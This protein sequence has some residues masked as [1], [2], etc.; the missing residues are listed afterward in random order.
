[1]DCYAHTIFKFQCPTRFPGLPAPLVPVAF[2]RFVLRVGGSLHS[3]SGSH[4]RVKRFFSSSFRFQRLVSFVSVRFRLAFPDLPDDPEFSSVPC[5]EQVS[6]PDRTS[7]PIRVSPFSEALSYNT[8]RGGVRQPSLQRK[9]AFFSAFQN[10]YLVLLHMDIAS[11]KMSICSD[12][13]C[14]SHKGSGCFPYEWD[15]VAHGLQM[16]QGS[17][18]A[19][20]CSLVPY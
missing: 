7:C 12:A 14:A 4:L 13:K 18:S 19:A 8:I 17:F 15:I 6:N 5:G 2:Q 9:S 20:A 1:M 11:S 16:E 3:L 10:L